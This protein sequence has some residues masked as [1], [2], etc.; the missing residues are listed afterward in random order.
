LGVGKFFRYSG[1][2]VPSVVISLACSV[3]YV[4]VMGGWSIG[5]LRD[6]KLWETVYLL[7]WVYSYVLF[8]WSVTVSMIGAFYG[9]DRRVL[10]FRIV[11]IYFSLILVFSGLYYSM[12]AS[13]DGEDA[14]RKY[15]YYRHESQLL[16]SRLESKPRAINSRR[17]FYGMN[18]R[19]WAGVDW[20]VGIKYLHSY[21]DPQDVDIDIEGMMS[22]ARH[23]RVVKFIPAARRDVF[24]DCLHFSVA[25]ISTLGY[26]D[27]VPKS[28]AAKIA[29]DL[30]VI[31]GVVLLAIALG[32]ALGGG[33]GFREKVGIARGF[34]TFA[35][36]VVVGFLLFWGWRRV[37]FGPN[38]EYYDWAFG[39]FNLLREAEGGRGGEAQRRAEHFLLLSSKYLSDWNYG[40]VIHDANSVLGLLALRAGDLQNAKLYL[41][42]AGSTPG[43]PQLDSFGPNM[44][45]A[46]QLLKRGERDAVLQYLELCKLFWEGKEETLASWQLQIKSGAVP[47]LR[48]RN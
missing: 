7:L 33:W 45:L 12:A 40:N 42:E 5:G 1:W 43:S 4:E 39:S 21:Y 16:K 13:S 44:V 15:N 23:R 35:G 14:Y 34:K 26:G 20:P 2:I 27:I 18:E 48:V 36:F 41:L 8:I 19:L 3:G 22:V 11:V 47:E 30:Q 10:V 38:S 17:A 37:A 46:A 25:T 31:S 28:M 24:I 9:Q 6:I 32:M 29:S